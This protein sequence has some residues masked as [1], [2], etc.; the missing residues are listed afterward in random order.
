MRHL[1]HREGQRPEVTQEA[2]E[3]GLDFFAVHLWGLYSLYKK[4]YVAWEGVVISS[5]DRPK[6]VRWG[7]PGAG[8]GGL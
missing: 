5:A 3:V 6:C 4:K 8:A 2:A 1:R 7:K